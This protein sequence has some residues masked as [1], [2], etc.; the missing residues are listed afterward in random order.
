MVR[1]GDRDSNP[2]CLIQSHAFWE[3][4]TQSHPFP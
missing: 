2:N 3:Q 4:K 1:L